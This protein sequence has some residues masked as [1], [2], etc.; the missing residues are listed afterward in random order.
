MNWVD[1]KE[2]ERWD[3]C[4]GSEQCDVRVEEAQEVVKGDGGVDT[5]TGAL[6]GDPHK[7]QKK[8]TWEG[9]SEG[10]KGGGWES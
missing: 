7:R 1:R 10:G 4:V 6:K 2:S 9:E 3:L 5:W 8:G